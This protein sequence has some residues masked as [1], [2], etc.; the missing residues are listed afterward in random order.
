MKNFFSKHHKKVTFTNSSTLITFIDNCSYDK[1]TV[2]ECILSLE[3]GESVKELISSG[4]LDTAI[5]GCASLKYINMINV[6]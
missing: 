2:E 1:C 6:Y 4:C 5:D 3:S